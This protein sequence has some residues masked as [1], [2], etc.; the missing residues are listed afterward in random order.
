MLKS[1][2]LTCVAHAASAILKTNNTK[3]ISNYGKNFYIGFMRNLAGNPWYNTRMFKLVVSAEGSSPVQFNVET[4]SGVVYSGTATVSSPVTVN[5][6]TSLLV[7]G[8]SYTYRN[9]G[10]HVYTSGHG[11]IS[12][13]VINSWRNYETG[14]YLAYPCED[15]GGALY[16]YY[17]VSTLTP[18]RQSEFLLIGCDDNTTIT[19]T[20]TQTVSIPADVNSSFSNLVSVSSG[21]SRQ[22]TLHKMQT[23]LIGKSSADLTGSRIVSNKPLTVISGHEC[24]K[25]PSAEYSGCTYLAEQ[26]S[27]TS[28]WGQKYFLVPFGGRFVGQYYK[29]V[30]SRDVTTVIRTCNLVTASETLSPA[31]SYFT[32]FTSSTTYCSVVANKP[33]LVA[34][35]GLSRVSNDMGGPIISILPSLDQYRNQYSFLSLNTTDFNNH[36]IS[37]SVLAQYYQPNSIRLDGQP[38][39]CS[40]SAI[41]NNGGTIVGYGC[42]R[43]VTGGTTHIV[44]HYNP[45][46]K[47]TVLVHGWSLSGGYGHLAGLH[48]RSGTLHIQVFE[49][50]IY[51]YDNTCTF[52]KY[53]TSHKLI[54]W[55]NLWSY[56]IWRCSMCW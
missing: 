11:S 29:I 47:L 2:L 1:F 19:I 28:T 26:I 4:S 56:S 5:L 53:D 41:Y 36:Q 9:K 35:L 30:S 49:N 18:V 51:C 17:I 44:S 16:E 46:G 39:N 22:I 45:I 52:R 42:H 23:L 15:N 24:S 25:V 8:V 13:L 55:L 40:W 43:S 54:L 10:V 38:I 34:Q 7:N 37:V 48:N 32:F 6:P 3:L 27:P 14:E 21:D 31:G 20:P 50:V 33:I 12:V